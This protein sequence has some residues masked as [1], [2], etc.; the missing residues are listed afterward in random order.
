MRRYI[1]AMKKFVGMRPYF[2]NHYY[3][4]M[5]RQNRPKWSHWKFL[6]LA[7]LEGLYKSYLT[8]FDLVLEDPAFFI[9][10]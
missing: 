7:S 9:L 10:V 3:E 6:R 1:Y 2:K 5:N 4:Q 8:I